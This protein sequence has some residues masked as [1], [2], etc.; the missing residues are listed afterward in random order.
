MKPINIK[1]LKENIDGKGM[2]NA[3]L[4]DVREPD[5]Y[6]EGHIPEAI[7][8]PLGEI[9]LKFGFLNKYDAIYVVCQTGGRSQVACQSISRKLGVKKKVVNIEGGTSAWIKSGYKV[10]KQ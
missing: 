4:I 10:I 7:N 1:E 3:V 6:S 5:E 9:S 8:I 2:G